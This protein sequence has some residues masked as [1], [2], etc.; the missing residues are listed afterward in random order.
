MLHEKYSVFNLN[1]TKWSHCYFSV[2][3]TSFEINVL[4][5]YERKSVI[6][7]YITAAI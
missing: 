4:N 6:Q 5:Y 2:P 3:Q 7:V 1:F